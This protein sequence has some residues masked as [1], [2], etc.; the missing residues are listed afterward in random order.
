MLWKDQLAIVALWIRMSL[1]GQIGQS[2]YLFEMSR[3]VR[4]PQDRI[5]ANGRPAVHAGSPECMRPRNR[6]T[7]TRLLRGSCAQAPDID[8]AISVWRRS[9]DR[10]RR[11]VKRGNLYPE[12]HQIGVRDGFGCR[13]AVPSECAGR[14][15]DQVSNGLARG[16]IACRGDPVYRIRPIDLLCFYFFWSHSPVLWACRDHDRWA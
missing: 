1:A 4:T 12:Q 3:K 7:E 14:W 6:T 11:R 13:R 2:R 10:Q 9:Q 15:L 8:T 5:T 16:M